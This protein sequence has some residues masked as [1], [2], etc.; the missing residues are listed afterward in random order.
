MTSQTQQATSVNRRDFLGNSALN[1]AGVAVGMWTIGSPSHVEANDRIR[2]G[3]IGL[4]QQG[5]E[6]GSLL[7]QFPA[8]E[9]NAICD[10]DARALAVAQDELSLG[11]RRPIAVSRHEQLLERADVDAVVIAAP[12]HWQAQLAVDASLA[13]KDVY[14]EQPVAHSIEEGTKLE[15]VVNQ[16]G[17]ILQTGLPQRS[18]AHFASAVRLL[19]SGEIGRVHLAK[20]WAVHRRRSLGRCASTQPPQGVDFERWL[21]PAPKQPFRPNRFHGDWPW[22][23]EFG[24]GELGQWG[25]Q[26]LDV[27]R[28]GMDLDLPSRIIA[29]GSNNA[30]RDDRETPDTMTV[31]YSFPEVDVIWEHR[32]W[33]RRGI[34]GRTAASAFYGDRG[35]LVVDRSGWKVYD[36]KPGLFADASDMKRSHLKDWL[37][38]IRQRIPPSAPIDVGQRSMTLCHLGNIAWRLGREIRFDRDSMNFGDDGEANQLLG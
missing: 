5:R 33:S 38:A 12:E 21:G 27:V 30:F 10:V 13:G 37:D 18:G 9:I 3:L 32:Q 14:L 36:G 20:A 11:R 35:T 19:Q 15:A 17:T 4:G 25:V 24:S 31:Q 28:W 16:Q 2:I 23:W 34:E 1:A 6:L 29:T 22:F 26:L 8:V 7:N